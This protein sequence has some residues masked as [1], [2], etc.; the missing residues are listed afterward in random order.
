[1]KK[2]ISF[3]LFGNRLKYVQ[4]MVENARLAPQIYPGWDCVAHVEE[5]HP[6]IPELIDLGVRIVEHAPEQGL[7]GAFWRFETLSMGYDVVIC[8][9]ADSRLHLRDS[10]CVT[11]WLKSGK[12]LHVM[13]DHDV[14]RPIPAG[15]F[16]VRIDRV[17]IEKDLALWGQKHVYGDDERFLGATVWER[18]KED[19]LDHRRGTLREGE[20][21]FP[22]EAEHSFR[23]GCACDPIKGGIPVFRIGGAPNRANYVIPRV[24][25]FSRID[26]ISKAHLNAAKTLLRRGVFPCMVL[27]EDAA[28]CRNPLRKNIPETFDWLWVGLSVYETNSEGKT[29]KSFGVS[30]PKDGLIDMGGMLALHGVVYGSPE[31]AKRMVLAA[32]KAL[33]EGIPVDVALVLLCR[34]NGWKRKGLIS[35]WVFQQGKNSN[36][37]KIDLT[38]RCKATTSLS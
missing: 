23:V 16:G 18:L 29:V 31:G 33:R 3:S 2:A 26:N 28:F 37:T 35:P 10:A 5:N 7:G 1:M 15:L 38:N 30:D 22:K 19:R 24:S 8:R 32:E 36:V 9:D 21:P 11:E 14:K 27:E 6:V 13:R 17:N 25:G 12:S 20:V 34:E 4:G